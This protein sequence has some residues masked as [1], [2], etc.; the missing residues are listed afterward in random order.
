MAKMNRTSNTN[1]TSSKIFGKEFSSEVIAVLRFL[2]LVTSLIGRRI[3][4]MRRVLKVEK[5]LE[6]RIKSM[7]ET[8]T[9]KKSRQFHVDFKKLFSPLDTNPSVTILMITS[10][11]NRQ[12]ITLSTDMM[13]F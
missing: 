2:F 10:N 13:N 1:V 7:S 12:V 11:V 8:T 6:F 5:P 9:I 4:T 3:R